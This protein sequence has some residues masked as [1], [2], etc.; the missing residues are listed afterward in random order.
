MASQREDIFELQREEP[1][2]CRSF[3][4]AVIKDRRRLYISAL[5]KQ[6]MTV[7]KFES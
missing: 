6:L 3:L 2:E 5:F 4:F 7:P 1:N